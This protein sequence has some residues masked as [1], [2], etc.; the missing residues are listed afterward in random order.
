MLVCHIH[1]AAAFNVSLELQGGDCSNQLTLICRHSNTGIAPLWIHNGTDESGE[2]LGTAFPGAVHTVQAV[3]EHTTTITGI[4]NVQTLDGYLIQCVYNILG[5]LTKSNAV[6]YSFIPPGQSWNTLLG[7]GCASTRWC[8]LLKIVCACTCC[9]SLPLVVWFWLHVFSLWCVDVVGI[10]YGTISTLMY[11]ICTYLHPKYICPES[12]VG[13]YIRMYL[14]VSNIHYIITVFLLHI[15]LRQ[16][17]LSSWASSGLLFCYSADTIG[18]NCW[19][20]KSLKTWSPILQR[21]ACVRTSSLCATP[22]VAACSQESYWHLLSWPFHRKSHRK[23]SFV[24]TWCLHCIS[25]KNLPVS[26]YLLRYPCFI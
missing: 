18:G 8:L 26:Y 21:H 9:W 5:N 25:G 12:I 14:Q 24:R 13:I 11:D 1:F 19:F 23:P 20:T 15:N 3:T 7:L 6:K 2:A 17:T 22:P 10:C 16:Y 4:G